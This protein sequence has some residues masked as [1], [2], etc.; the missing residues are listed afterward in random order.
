MA[1]TVARIDEQFN[2]SIVAVDVTTGLMRWKFQTVHHDIWD[3]DL[4]SQGTF[5]DFPTRD[6]PVPALILPT[7]Q[8]E[9][10]VFDRRSGRC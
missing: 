5:V 9:I 3:Y 4:G 1:A 10:Y 6:G 7:K 8:G 2:S